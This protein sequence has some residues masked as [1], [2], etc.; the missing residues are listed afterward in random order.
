MKWNI[1]IHN[2][3]GFNDPESID[4]KREF[5]KSI[6]PRADVIFLQEHKLRGSSLD[7]LGHRIMPECVSWILEAAP[8]ERSWA[9][10][11]AA[12]KGEVRILLAH[13]YT[14]LVTAHGS[15][16]ND[17]VVWIKLEG[18]E[19]GNIGLP[20]IYAPNISTERRHLWRDMMKL[21]PKDCDWILGGDFNLTER[22]EDKSN[23]CRRGISDIKKLTWNGLFNGFQVLNTFTY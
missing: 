12:G 21:L 15:L 3:R 2:I 23:D 5:I 18:I 11:D 16:F 9:N 14:R 22:K 19:G 13:T 10:P 20:C 17:R 1:L 8:G 7:N 4:K 6:L